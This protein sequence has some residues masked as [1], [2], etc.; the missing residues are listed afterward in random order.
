MRRSTYV[1]VLSRIYRDFLC[2][3]HDNNQPL[4]KASSVRFH[5]R[6]V[7]DL[8]SSSPSYSSEGWFGSMPASLGT[9]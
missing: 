6:N 7:N 5:R 9:S 1:W 2:F 3:A 8:G 4:D